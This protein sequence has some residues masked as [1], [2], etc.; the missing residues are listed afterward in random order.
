MNCEQLRDHYELFALGLVDEP[1]RSEIRDHLNRGCETCRRGV[2]EALEMT[3]L[4]GSTAPQHDPP[5][6]LRRRILASA[7]VEPRPMRWA[8]WWA[9]AAALS[10]AGA[11]YL[12]Y[13]DWQYAADSSLLR[14]ELRQQQAEVLRLT[15]AFAILNSPFT[16]DASFGSGQPQPPRGRVFWNPEQ[17]VL[18]I[19][20][21]LPPAPAGKRYEMWVIPKAGKPVPAGTFQS[22]ADG[23]AMHLRAGGLDVSNTGAFAVTVEDEAGADQPTSQPLIVVPAAAR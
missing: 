3:V 4:L 9:A 21:N 13:R 15:E 11:A 17:G 14:S 18:L 19:A 5:D 2:K 7:G 22:R 8:A 20:S 6:A 1:E 10:L 23:T 12:G 16:R